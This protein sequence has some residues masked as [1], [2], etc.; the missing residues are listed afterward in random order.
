MLCLRC[1]GSRC[2]APPCL[3][4]LLPN[5]LLLGTCRVDLEVAKR[6]G[7][8]KQ[9]W[10][11]EKVE[12]V[13]AQGAAAAAAA[14]AAPSCPFPTAAAGTSCIVPALHS[15]HPLP[16]PAGVGHCTNLP[17]CSPYQLISITPPPVRLSACTCPCLPPACSSP[18]TRTT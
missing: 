4:V 6:T 18:A 13:R 3:L 17:H 8:D 15:P 14:A 5:K 12:P 2:A 7:N 1:S 9:K 16:L 10:L 11:V